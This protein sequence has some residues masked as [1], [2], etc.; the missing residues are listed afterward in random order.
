[1]EKKATYRI[2]TAH[3]PHCGKDKPVNPGNWSVD[4][5]N[6]RNGGFRL[7][8]C[9]ACIA[10]DARHKGS[11]R[12]EE[13]VGTVTKGGMTVVRLL[14][15]K[16]DGGGWRTFYEVRCPCG[17]TCEVHRGKLNQRRSCGCNG[18]R[19]PEGVAAF[20][21]VYRDYKRKAKKRGLEWSLSEEFFREIT[22]RDCVYCGVKP[23][24]CTTKNTGDFT[25]NGVD[26]VDS[27]LG[28]YEG[29]VVPCCGSCNLAKGVKS[30]AEWEAW[31]A[32]VTE[33]RSRAAIGEPAGR[34][35]K[36][37]EAEL[38][39]DVSL[40]QVDASSVQADVSPVQVDAY[41]AE[42]FQRFLDTGE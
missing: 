33:F 20:N 9:R 21:E 38:Q 15:L 31:L 1:M 5:R 28:Y 12:A 27:D 17:N 24:N 34:D 14:G 19:K 36:R 11:P 7:Y 41:D 40:I 37:H 30:L 6:C 13:L 3:C 35:A 22:Q 39:A 29:N 10:A 4:K 8:K 16:Q 2:E 23:N 32:R 18:S 26:R 42:V 25:Y